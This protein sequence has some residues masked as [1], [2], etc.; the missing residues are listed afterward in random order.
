MKIYK[1]NFSGFCFGVKRAIQIAKESAKKFKNLYILGD[2]VHNENVY[3]EIEKLGIKKVKSLKETP[4]SSFLLIKAHG[5]AKNTYQEARKRKLKIIDATCPRVKEIH[6]KTQEL[7][8]KGYQV[9]IVGDKNHQETK[10]ILGNIKEGIVLGKENDLK[11]IK[12]KKRIAVLSQSTQDIEKVAKITSLLLKNCEELFFVNTICVANR[13]RQKEV[14]KLAKKCKAVLV[15]GSRKSANT[16][17]LYEKSIRL[18]KNT[19]WISKPKIKKERFSKF[20]SIGIIGGASTPYDDL[21]KIY[22]ILKK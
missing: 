20:T 11:K 5:E 10:G 3:R 1:A 19:F 16:K 17:R 7:E 12:L 2:L 8:K 18:N 4:F 9:V 13:L 14:E 21:E 15:V 6:Q 22:K